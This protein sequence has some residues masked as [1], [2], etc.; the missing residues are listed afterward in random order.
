MQ[1]W[2]FGQ[3][4]RGLL[5][6]E[7]TRGEKF[8]WKVDFHFMTLKTSNRLC[9]NV[10]HNS[11]AVRCGGGWSWRLSV[12][13]HTVFIDDEH[14]VFTEVSRSYLTMAVDTGRYW[15]HRQSRADTDVFILRELPHFKRTLLGYIPFH[16]TALTPKSLLWIKYLSSCFAGTVC[17]SKMCFEA[18]FYWYI[19]NIIKV[20]E[21][22]IHSSTYKREVNR[23]KELNIQCGSLVWVKCSL[24]GQLD[25][26][27][28][29]GRKLQKQDWRAFCATV[30]CF[31]R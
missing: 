11:L 22:T 27:N 13:T 5:F 18:I 1:T 9:E 2:K 19:W 29:R 3:T 16:T 30:T 20:L 7:W 23:C 14:W 25:W 15:A 8:A 24:C 4:P 6:A 31:R 26:L 17:C 10:Q 28:R 12:R 21:Q